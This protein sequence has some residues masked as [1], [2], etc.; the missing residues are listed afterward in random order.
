MQRFIYIYVIFTCLVAIV[1]TVFETQPALFIIDIFAP[2][3]GDKY[4]VALV[5]LLTWLLLILPLVI[6][7]LIAKLARK[8]DNEIIAPDRTGIFVTRLKAFQSSLVGISFYMNDKKVGVIDNG[9]TKFFDAT[10]G[11]HTIYAGV[12]VHITEKLQIKIEEGNQL[13]FEIKILASSLV[14]KIVIRQL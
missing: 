11:T 2:N 8:K 4:F 14:I 5:L 6:Y 7:L 9:R 13:R 12:G 1:S 3:V 10:A